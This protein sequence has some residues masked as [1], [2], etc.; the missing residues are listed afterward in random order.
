MCAPGS[1]PVRTC[2]RGVSRYP[3]LESA[4]HAAGAPHIF[5]ASRSSESARRLRAS[6]RLNRSC[7]GLA[8]PNAQADLQDEGMVKDYRCPE[9]FAPV[10]R[11]VGPACV[12][13]VW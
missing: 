4:A 11:G 12:R 13:F 7:S 1:L 8:L 6:S 5:S 3:D 10:V 2:A 9:T